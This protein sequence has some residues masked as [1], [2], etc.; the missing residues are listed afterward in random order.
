[1]PQTDKEKAM[2]AKLNAHNNS[3]LSEKQF[4]DAGNDHEIITANKRHNTRQ[5]EVDK[6]AEEIEKELPEIKESINRIIGYLSDAV[7]YAENIQSELERAKD[8]KGIDID[9]DELGYLIHDFTDLSKHTCERSNFSDEQ[10]LEFVR[11]MQDLLKFNKK[12]EKMN[13]HSKGLLY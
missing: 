9:E 5:A 2:W 8:G 13:E 6:M 12:I 3:G 11:S 1:M 4:A 7:G 10:N